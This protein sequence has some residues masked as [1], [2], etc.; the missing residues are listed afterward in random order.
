MKPPAL[1]LGHEGEPDK[2]NNLTGCSRDQKRTKATK[3]AG[4]PGAPAALT[5]IG[6]APPRGDGAPRP[7]P[8]ASAKSR[9]EA[10]RAAGTDAGRDCAQ[11]GAAKEISF[12]TSKKSLQNP[13]RV[14]SGA[15]Q[16]CKLACLGRVYDHIVTVVGG[17]AFL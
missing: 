2:S 9:V 13:G 11:P 15:F 14:Y 8:S 3:R 4:V 10:K 17:W 7:G 6:S 1:S 16:I 5:L 12:F